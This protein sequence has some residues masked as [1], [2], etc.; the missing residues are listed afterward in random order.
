MLQHQEEGGLFLDVVGTQGTMIS[1]HVLAKKQI[2]PV[3]GDPLLVPE[4]SLDILDSVRRYH[5]KSDGL[6]YDGLYEDL[7]TTTQ[8]EHQVKGGLFLDVIVVRGTTVFELLA[9][10]DQEYMYA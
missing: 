1:E 9:S 8:A 7:H 6:A 2:L 4:L 10:K 5:F 3:R